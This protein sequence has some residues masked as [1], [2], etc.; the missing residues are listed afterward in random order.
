M[1][2]DQVSLNSGYEKDRM[3]HF[4]KFD[5]I[6]TIFSTRFFND[7]TDSRVVDMRNSGEQMMLNL[8]I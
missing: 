2:F 7:F 6:N 3:S 5:I 8:K 1:L 4:G